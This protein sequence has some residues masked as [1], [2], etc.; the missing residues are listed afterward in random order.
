MIL[1]VKIETAEHKLA[2][3]K[4]WT[5]VKFRQ[6]MGV[7]DVVSNLFYGATTLHS[8]QILGKM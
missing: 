6:H 4:Y 1:K 5:F 8:F 3:S 7:V 2:V